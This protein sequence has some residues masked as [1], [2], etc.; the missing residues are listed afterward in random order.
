MQRKTYYEDENFKVYLEKIEDQPF[1][2]VAIF[3]F[4]K[5]I[6]R[7]IKR[8][9]A[10]VVVTFYFEGYENLFAYTKDNRIIKL[11]GGAKMIGQHQ[12]YEVWEWDLK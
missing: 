1:V 11:I 9:W 7:E 5:A 12:D 8:V 10:D 2:H 3:N 6:L 4:S